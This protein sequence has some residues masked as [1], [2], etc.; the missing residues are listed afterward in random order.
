MLISN[1]S[2]LEDCYYTFAY[3]YIFTIWFLQFSEWLESTKHLDFVERDCASRLDLIA[4]VRGLTAAENYIQNIPKSFRGELIYRTLLSN[5]V[6]AQDVTKAEQVFGK[7]KDLKLSITSFAY[8]Q[9]IL[10][11][12]KD[13]KNKIADVL[14]QMEKENVKPTRDTYRI[15][16]D[17]KGLSNDITGMEQIVEIMK[18]EGIEP[19]IQ[20]QATLANHYVSGG[21]VEKAEAVLKEMEGENIK[22]NQLMACVHLL[23]LYAS[24]GKADEVARLWKVCEPNSQ[25]AEYKA[26]IEAWGKLNKIEEAEAVF[27]RMLRKWKRLYSKHHLALLKVYMDHK[28]LTK[29]EELVKKMVENGVSIGPLVWDALVKLYV[30]AG[31]VKKADL[32]LEKASEGN[33]M[34]PLFSSYIAIMEE[35][36]KRGDVHNAER[37][38]DRLTQVGYVVRFGRYRTLVEAYVKAN[39]PAYGMRERG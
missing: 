19:D 26:A 32:Y 30:E 3:N 2:L 5:C 18:A 4:K 22:A 11:Y 24:L 16:I 6:A 10:L 21:L 37:I 33:Q 38:F 12:K 36:A 34:K 17:A 8:N 28:M 23:P 15:L 35:Y 27:D 31:E 29:G 1:H 9:L 25:F 13:D 39:R 20:T 7:M 14:L